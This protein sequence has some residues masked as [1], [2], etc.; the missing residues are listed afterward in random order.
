MLTKEQIQKRNELIRQNGL[1]TRMKRANQICKTFKFKIDYRNL[2]RQQKECIKMMFVE[3]KW[4]YNYIL[5]Q[6]DVYS[7]DYKTLTTVTHKDKNKNDIVSN[8]QY[9]KSSVRQELITQ[10]TN[11]IK[12]LHKL[13]E[14]GHAV[15]KLRFKSEFNSIVLKQYGITHSIRGSKFKIQGIKDPIRVMGLKQLD[16]YDNIDF[17]TARLTY[18]GLDYFVCLT[19]YIDK[20]NNGKSYDNDIIGIDMGVKDTI[21]LSN[22]TKYNISIGESEK[23]KRLERKLAKQK[24]GSNNRYKTIKK[25]RKEHI[26]INNKKNDISNKIVHDILSKNKIVVIQ[27]EQIKSWITTKAELKEIED[28][29]EKEKRKKANAKIQHSVL[30]RIKSKLSS[31]DQIVVL[32]KWFPTTKYCFKCGEKTN[33]SVDERIFECHNCK[34]KED[35]DIHAAKNMIRFYLQYSKT[36]PGTDVDKPVHKINYRKFINE[37]LCGR[38]VTQL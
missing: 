11:Q 10:I 37:N 35:R 33:I 32:D 20:D 8:I 38:K 19:C 34:L 6:K 18:D 23:L 12:G 15:G 5:S 25:I 2:N 9:V 4:I 3:S 21:T 26:H 29:D 36:T 1:A 24:K 22:G 31:S 7:I 28:K 13:K 27:D 17:T 16:K 30:G 14:K